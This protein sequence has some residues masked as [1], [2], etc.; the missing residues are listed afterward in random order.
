[1]R[2]E[3]TTSSWPAISRAISAARARLDASLRRA[4]GMSAF[5]MRPS[6]RSAAARKPR[7]WRGSMPERCSSTSDLSTV[8]HVFAEHVGRHDERGSHGILQQHRGGASLA[9]EL[10]ARELAF[11]REHGWRSRRPA[12]Q[13]GRA[14]GV[15]LRKEP[16]DHLERQVV[17]ALHREHEPQPIHV[18]RRELA[19]PRLGARRRNELP[20]LEK[21][22]LRRRQIWELRAELREHLTD[23]EEVR[24]SRHPRLDCFP[25]HYWARCARSRRDA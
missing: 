12:R 13:H 5:S 25:C 24:S 16:A 8:E 21:P 20:L 22:Q 23:T 4:T 10:V 14:A 2:L 7:R 9:H 11:A 3:R 19:V 1:M 17:I 6:S 18:R 15:E